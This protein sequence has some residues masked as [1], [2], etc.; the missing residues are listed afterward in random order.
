MDTLFAAAQ[1]IARR[2]TISQDQEYLY[3][4]K[5]FLRDN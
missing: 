1:W 3:A 4:F 2:R 5:K